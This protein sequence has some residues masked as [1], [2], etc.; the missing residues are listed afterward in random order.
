MAS[1]L[2][3]PVW[4]RSHGAYSGEYTTPSFALRVVTRSYVLQPANRSCVSQR[5]QR[6]EKR[7][8]D[9]VTCGAQ[10]R[11]GPNDRREGCAS[12]AAGR[13]MAAAPAGLGEPSLEVLTGGDEQTFT[14]HF[15]QPTEAEVAQAVPVFGLTE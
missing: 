6:V 1:S 13:S 12:E 8:Q 3:S 10:K 5:V 15:P 9:E 7:H 14:I 4:R 11:S 2:A